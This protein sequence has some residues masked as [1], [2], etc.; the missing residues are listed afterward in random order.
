MF[1]LRPL[2]VVQIKLSQQEQPYQ[3]NTYYGRV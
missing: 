3:M 2:Q 1:V